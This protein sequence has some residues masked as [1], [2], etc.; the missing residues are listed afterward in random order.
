MKKESLLFLVLQIKLVILIFILDL[1]SLTVGGF[2]LIIGAIYL[3]FGNI[4][5]SLFC[6]TIA[7]LYWLVNAYQHHDIFGVIS[8]AFGIIVGLSV[9]YKMKSGIFVKTLQKE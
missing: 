4:Y 1:S 3:Y 2:E 7:D 9:A 8:I 6:Y 5:Y